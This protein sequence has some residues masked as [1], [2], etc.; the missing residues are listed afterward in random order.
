MHEIEIEKQRIERKRKKRR[1]ITGL[2]ILTVLI[3]LIAMTAAAVYFYARGLFLKFSQHPID[4]T[5]I[6]INEQVDRELKDYDNI[7]IL[8]ADAR[9]KENTLKT[10][11][12]G[13]ILMSLNKNSGKVKMTSILRDSFLRIDRDGKSMLDKLTHAHAFGGPENTVRALNRNLDL[14]ISKYME[15]NWYTV[16]KVADALGGL[17]F[18]IKE[19]EINEMNRY[20][21]DTNRH[22]KGSTVHIKKAGKQ[23][24]NGIQT[25]TYCRIRHVGNGDMERASRMRIAI[26]AAYKKIKNMKLDEI[27][28]FAE[29]VFPDIYTN[30]TP[31]EMMGLA[32]MLP[33]VKIENQKSW[34]Y[35]FDGINIDG[36]WYDAPIM[37]DRNVQLLHE[38]LFGQKK[39]KI[40]RIVQEISDEIQ[41]KTGF[42]PKTP[43]QG[44]TL[45]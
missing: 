39:F 24:L 32:L 3:L 38:R 5:K 28:K 15:V 29:K 26:E 2:I 20:I 14:N 9:H 45:K 30:I 18:D 19:H 11:S 16:E 31:E 4:K 10:R 34:P 44:E 8:G 27:E 13:I 23:V 37:H 12:D 7:L 40:S 1:R 25:V 35:S 41:Q 36:V 21:D 42:G 17:E 33:K 43:S 22:L 6:E